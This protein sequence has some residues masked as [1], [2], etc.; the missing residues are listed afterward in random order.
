MVS[1]LGQAQMQC[2]S[3]SHGYQSD[4]VTQAATCNVAMASLKSLS[5]RFADDDETL[6]LDLRFQ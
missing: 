3:T 5:H 2:S 6:S 4:L 1:G